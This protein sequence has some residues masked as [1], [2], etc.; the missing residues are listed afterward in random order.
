MTPF[1]IT[2]LV[3]VGV[4]LTLA[5]VMSWILGWAN[6]AFRVEV[7]PKVAEISAV[8]PGANCGACGFAGC[9]EYAAQLVAGTAPCGACTQCNAEKNQRIAQILGVAAAET[10][11]YKAVVH[12]MANDAQRIDRREYTGERT[13][14]AANLV[15]GV[16]GCT[17]G[18]LGFGDCER[19]CKY[20]G[21]RVV[22]GLATVYYDKCVG[23]K[24]CEA[25]CPR[26]IISI[27]PFKKSRVLV[28]ACSNRDIGPDVRGVCKVGCIGC[29]A[30]SRRDSAFQM[31]E[32]L[33]TIDYDAFGEDDAH[34]VTVEKC[35]AN[36]LVYV[37]EPTAQ[38][39]AAT[40]DEPL[41]KVVQADFKTTVDQTKW[42]G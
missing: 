18:C 8:L 26:H 16:Q 2:V 42:R 30:C 28:V 35:P 14:A 33:P 20:G 19:S 32:N 25:A 7:D 24:A 37:G 34:L 40:Q 41:P 15:S 1:T 9:N 31:A 39:I 5:V 29:G 21:I 17:Y 23:C 27:I 3:A 22:N 12:C 6:V 10:F 11:P 13:C 38:D 4:M 36:M